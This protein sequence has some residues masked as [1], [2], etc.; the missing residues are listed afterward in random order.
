[1]HAMTINSSIAPGQWQRQ[2]R[3]QQHLER[4]GDGAADH[5]AAEQRESRQPRVHS[6]QVDAGRRRAV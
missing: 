1:M 5:G 6:D 2:E 4:G 3:A